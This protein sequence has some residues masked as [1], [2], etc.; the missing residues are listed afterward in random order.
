MIPVYDFVE[1]SIPLLVSVPH[2]GRELALG[3]KER[4]TAIGLALPDTDWYVRRLYQFAPNLGASVISANYS[5]YVIDLNRPSTDEELYKGQLFTGLCP[6]KTFGGEDIYLEGKTVSQSE[7][8]ERIEQYWQPYHHK[9]STELAQ[10]K[11]KFGFGLLWDA[12]SI[13]SRVP[14]LFSGTLKIL[15]IGTVD[16]TSCDHRLTEAVH[17]F[18]NESE[19]SAVVDGRFK[20]G[21]ITRAHGN[22]DENV[23]ALQLEKAQRAY[24]YEDT[25]IYDETAAERFVQCLDTMLSTYVRTA[26]ALY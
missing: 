11:E 22:P 3:M 12:H 25:L 6:S 18:A 26:Q 21:Y 20:G 9:V 8:Q 19:Y 15:N 5:R 1:G 10:M 13:P 16:G 2:D 7:K 14:S 23:H 4:M 24:M 17:E